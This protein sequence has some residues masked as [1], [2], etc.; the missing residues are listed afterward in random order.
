M[1]SSGY[2]SPQKTETWN[3]TLGPTPETKGGDGLVGTLKET[4][5]KHASNHTQRAPHPSLPLNTESHAASTSNQDTGAAESPVGCPAPDSDH[6]AM[7]HDVS[8]GDPEETGAPEQPQAPITPGDKPAFDTNPSFKYNPPAPQ[9]DPRA[10]RF[11]DTIENPCQHIPVPSAPTKN[12]LIE[13]LVRRN[14]AEDQTSISIKTATIC[15]AEARFSTYLAKHQHRMVTTEHIR[16]QTRDGAWYDRDTYHIPTHAQHELHKVMTVQHEANSDVLHT[17][18]DMADT[19]PYTVHSEA[20]HRGTPGIRNRSYVLLPQSTGTQRNHERWVQ[21]AAKQTE[22][23]S[24]E[25][26]RVDSAGPQ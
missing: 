5:E 13:E 15:E 3:P 23:G 21:R 7:A 22:W 17:V 12:K 25:D 16:R 11:Q 26:K 10:Y 14:T 6:D 20:E 9:T 1:Q 8:A 18:A 19:A 24:N 2:Q 4:F